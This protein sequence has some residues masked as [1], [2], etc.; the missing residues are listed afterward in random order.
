[1]CTGASTSPETEIVFMFA[2]A[3]AKNRAIAGLANHLS[4]CARKQ[5]PFSKVRVN[6]LV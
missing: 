6:E 1:M 3:Q 5:K 4:K 2:L